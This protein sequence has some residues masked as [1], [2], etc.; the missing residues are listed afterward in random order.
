ML[1]IDIVKP[2]SGRNNAASPSLLRTNVPGYFF[3]KLLPVPYLL[4]LLLVLSSNTLPGM[5][6][7][8]GTVIFLM[9]DFLCVAVVFSAW[10]SISIDFDL[11]TCWAIWVLLLGCSYLLVS[12]N[13]GEFSRYGLMI[14]ALLAIM[15]LMVVLIAKAGLLDMYLGAFVNT[16]ALVALVSLILWAIGPVFG[17]I[18]PNCS[19]VNR[20]G[21]NGFTWYTEGYFQLQYI[22]QWQNLPGGGLWRNTSF[23]AE[24][25]M[26]S[27]ALCCALIIECFF[28]SSKSRVFVSAILF[29]TIITTFSSSGIILLLG[30]VLFYA[31]GK[32]RSLSGN[33]KVLLSLLFLV[34]FCVASV[35]AILI[36]DQKMSTSSGSTRLDDYFAGFEAWRQSAWFGYGFSN[37]DVVKLY[38]SAFRADN[39]GFSNGPFQVMVI[40]G[41]V[42]LAPYLLSF[43]GYLHSKNFSKAAGI[44]LLYLWAVTLVSNLPLTIFMLSFG[45]CLLF[46]S[47]RLGGIFKQRGKTID[48]C[49]V[50]DGCV[51][52]DDEAVRLFRR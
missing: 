50:R 51:G 31:L 33:K 23:F 7:N 2:T 20:W 30:I 36:L 13:S 38:M 52:C 47:I 32:V 28:R 11:L 26:Y 21:G 10:I 35:A 40:G 9:I 39:L 34:L 22:P 42:W 19:I 49:V 12:L 27:F 44:L 41:V 24:S 15:P 14:A 1:S 46:P 3:C 29:I 45:I 8:R 48:A 25:P 17:L 43:F 16:M 18:A 4:A 37:I 5:V 6:G